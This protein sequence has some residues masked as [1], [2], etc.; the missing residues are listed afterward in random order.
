MKTNDNRQNFFFER[1]G[2]RIAFLISDIPRSK[3][4]YRAEVRLQRWRHS[5]HPNIDFYGYFD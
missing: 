3:D 1:D 2:R 4:A 5:R